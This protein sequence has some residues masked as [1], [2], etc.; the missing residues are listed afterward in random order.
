MTRLQFT[1]ITDRSTEM[2]MNSRGVGFFPNAK[3]PR[4]FW[5]GIEA[6]AN[7]GE[8]AAEIERR[9]EAIGIPREQRPFKPHLTLA[10]FKTEEGLP[11]L[12]EALAA[13]GSSE[14]GRAT[15]KEFHLYRSQLKPGGADYTRLATFPF[16]AGAQ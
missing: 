10:R 5:A 8:V 9:L 12:L 16:V 1:S 13:E 3:H 4:V 6:T 7:L 15:E 14:F 2:E 11:R